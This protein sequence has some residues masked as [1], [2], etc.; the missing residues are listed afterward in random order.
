MTCKERQRLGPQH[1]REAAA[2]G[3]FPLRLGQ[4]RLDGGEQRRQFG[5]APLPIGANGG[6]VAAMAPAVAVAF[7]RAA[8]LPPPAFADGCR[9]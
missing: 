6:A 9:N 3:D 4:H 8:F 1:R 7:G 5:L 2:K